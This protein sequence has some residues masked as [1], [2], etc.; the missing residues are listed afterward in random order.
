VLIDDVSAENAPLL[1]LPESHRGPVHD[2]FANG[3]FVGGFNPTQRGLD[4]SGAVAITGTAG[5]IS[6]HHVR[7]VHGSAINRS[8]RDRCILFIEIA[9]AD[10]WP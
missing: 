1:L 6:L 3:V 10:A 4:V 9:A 7:L 8:S 5:S 2:H